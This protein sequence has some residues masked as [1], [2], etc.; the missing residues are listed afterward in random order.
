MMILCF[1][2]RWN[3]A[4]IGLFQ[5]TPA[6]KNRVFRDMERVCCDVCKHKLNVRTAENVTW[7][8][9]DITQNMESSVL[10]TIVIVYQ[11]QDNT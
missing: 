7:F 8:I 2:T 3:P 10:I 5:F 6:E 1:H 11:V 9:T 4:K